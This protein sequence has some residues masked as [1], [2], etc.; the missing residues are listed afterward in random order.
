MKNYQRKKMNSSAQSDNIINIIHKYRHV[1][2]DL[3]NKDLKNAYYFITAILEINN[4]EINLILCSDRYIS[5][6]NHC[7]R[8]K[9]EPTDVLSFQ[10][11][12]F[13]PETKKNMLGEIVISLDRIQIQSKQYNTGF[14]NEFF[15]MFIHGLLHLTGMT[16]ETPEKLREMN[17][18]TD[19]IIKKL[20]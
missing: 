2:F 17:R 13:N 19:M 1:E 11:N 10:L 7:Y 9:E 15:R 16:H 18:K 8:S 12:E 4:C 20:I 14:K 6:L 5:K 3:K